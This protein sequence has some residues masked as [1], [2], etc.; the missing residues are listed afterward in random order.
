MASR[1]PAPWEG[2]RSD[3][4]SN[5]KVGPYAW[6]EFPNGDAADYPCVIKPPFR[7]VKFI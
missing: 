3:S 7:I 4:D 1:L 6:K 2:I 5:G